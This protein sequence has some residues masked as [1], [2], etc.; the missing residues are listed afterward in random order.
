M[1]FRGS[2]LFWFLVFVDVVVVVVVVLGVGG[3]PAPT[4]Q[5]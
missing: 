4:D 3:R 1:G 2:V 5:N